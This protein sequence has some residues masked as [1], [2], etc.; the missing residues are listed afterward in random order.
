MRAYGDE[1]DQVTRRS[2]VHSRTALAAQDHRVAI[3]DARRNGHPRSAAQPFYTGYDFSGT[4][5]GRA[6]TGDHHEAALHTHLT[7]TFAGRT[8]LGLGARLCA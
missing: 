5:A 8:R 6:G 1:D 2:S 4:A 7:G 3:V